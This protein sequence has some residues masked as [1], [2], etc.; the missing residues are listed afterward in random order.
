MGPWGPALNIPMHTSQSLS[1]PGL[2]MLSE[3]CLKG[4]LSTH[5]QLNMSWS[6]HKIGNAT[7][8]KLLLIFQRNRAGV[9]F[10]PFST[11]TTS[12]ARRSFT[13]K[14]GQ[15]M[16]GPVLTIRVAIF[17]SGMMPE[18]RSLCPTRMCTSR[19]HKGRLAYISSPSC[20]RKLFLCRTEHT[21]IHM[22]PPAPVKSGT[23]QYDLHHIILLFACWGPQELTHHT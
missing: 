13:G 11:L 17:S 18:Q 7:A 1:V 21:H 8:Q 10:Q 9:P 12:K 16:C 5:I 20:S 4:L 3:E 22:G 2:P 6:I 15:T 23:V 14:A 19:N